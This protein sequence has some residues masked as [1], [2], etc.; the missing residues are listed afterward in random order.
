M[1]GVFWGASALLFL[2]GAAA[3]VLRRQ[4]LAMLLGLELMVN[5]VNLALVHTSTRLGDSAGLAAALLIMA[6]AAAEA[7]VGLSLIL[8]LNQAGRAAESQAIAE[9]N[10]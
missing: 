2:C 5:A 1:T 10:G 7:V 3:L 8:K 4:L 9:L 6:V